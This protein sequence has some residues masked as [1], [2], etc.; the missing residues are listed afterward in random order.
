MNAA[1]LLSQN[2]G[3]LQFIYTSQKGHLPGPSDDNIHLL[4]IVAGLAILLVSAL[5][6]FSPAECLPQRSL[7]NIP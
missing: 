3:L 5:L 7:V 1:G 6:T 4:T 2:E